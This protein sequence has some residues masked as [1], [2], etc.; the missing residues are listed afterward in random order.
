MPAFRSVRF[1]AMASSSLSSIR[2]MQPLDAAGLME[3]DVLLDLDGKPLRHIDDLQRILTEE[4]VGVRI[5]MT[6]LRQQTEKQTIFVTPAE[7]RR[8]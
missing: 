3:G 5:P 8:A 6:L 7:N 2:R 1:K 4:K